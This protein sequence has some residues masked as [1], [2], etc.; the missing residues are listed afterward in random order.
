VTIDPETERQIAELARDPRP[1]LVLDV[2]DVLLEFIRPFPRF[3][4]KQGLQ[5]KLDSFRLFGNVVEVESGNA[6]AQDRV[7][8]LIDDFFV[9]QAE[10]QGLMEGAAETLEAFA[11]KAEIV[12]LTAMPHR[13]RE[14]RRVHL[15]ALGLGPAIKLL[16]GETDRPVAFVDDQPRNLVSA[17]D[18]VPD[19]CLVH[20][21]AHEEL[22]ALLPPVPH[23]IRSVETWDEARPIIAEGLG[24]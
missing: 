4:E 8:G 12:L 21:I 15:D 17:R 11:R 16:R 24:L 9:A 19:T 18:M 22:R 10:W 20:L 6:V 3:L 2:D 5:L 13:H 1:L 23:G 14:T 7:S